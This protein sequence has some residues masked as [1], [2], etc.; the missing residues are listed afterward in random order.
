MK[1]GKCS[2][3]VEARLLRF[4]EARNVKRGDELS[5]SILSLHIFEREKSNVFCSSL[6]IHP[7]NQ[8]NDGS[9]IWADDSLRL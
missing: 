8:L 1:T 6:P 3:I 9:D 7:L 5:L 2:S 4:W